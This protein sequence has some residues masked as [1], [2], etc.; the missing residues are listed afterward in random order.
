MNLGMNFANSAR[1]RGN[2]VVH[3]PE[4]ATTLTSLPMKNAIITTVLATSVACSLNAQTGSELTYYNDNDFGNLNQNGGVSYVDPTF[5][6]VNVGPE[7]C[8]PTSTIN[9][10]TMLENVDNVTLG[11]NYS[12]A[13]NG[14]HAVDQ[15]AAAMGTRNNPSPRVQAFGTTYSGMVNGVNS[16]IGAG[17]AN[18]APNVH[19]VGGQYAPNRSYNPATAP[20]AT[21]N[22]FVPSG[23]IGAV[24]AGPLANVAPT[25]SW[26]ASELN[27][28]SA[29]E[30]GIQWG[31]YVGQNFVPAGGGHAVTLDYINFNPQLNFG[32]IDFLDSDTLASGAYQETGT[33]QM[34]N[35][36]LEV[37]YA[38]TVSGTPS[39]PL[40][41]PQFL[42]QV[43]SAALAGGGETGR[44]ICDLAGMCRMAARP[45]CCS[46]PLWPAW[47]SSGAKIKNYL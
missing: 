10:M 36:Y 13:D 14:F 43:T 33:I 29:I 4:R 17:G 25:A 7:A 21:I 31:S 3:E 30:L 28:S 11:Q 23:F 39:D 46:A 18:P 32:T 12:I 6:G 1:T 24:P 5:G 8:A 9:A 27:M 42:P 19:I 41:D 47:A 44:I 26:M 35:G 45:R 38:T 2:G 40:D 22:S 34:I 15:L 37:S 20:Q 16:Y